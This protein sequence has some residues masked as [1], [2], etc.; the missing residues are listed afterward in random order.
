[1]INPMRTSAAV[2]KPRPV[3]MDAA[4]VKDAPTSWASDQ[5]APARTVSLSSA[6]MGGPIGLRS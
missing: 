2:Q 6:L 1:M 3:R 5:L 4:P